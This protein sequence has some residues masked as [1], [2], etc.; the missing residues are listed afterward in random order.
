M[1]VG[2][3]TEDVLVVKVGTGIG[4]GIIVDGRVYRGATGSAGDIGHIQASPADGRVVICHCGMEN[5]LSALAG[6][7]ALL[8]DPQALGLA[9]GTTPAVVELAG[10]GA[11]PALELVPD[12]GLTTRRVLAS[13]V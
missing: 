10:Q 4:C 2:G 1:G 8:R 7:R 9:V 3:S 12:A 13:L 11:G 5:S 6:G